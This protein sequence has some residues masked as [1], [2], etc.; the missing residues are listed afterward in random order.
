M[1]DKA[2]VKE[3]TQ[4]A[5]RMWAIGKMAK[6]TARVDSLTRLQTCIR[7][8]SET[9]KLMVKEYMSTQME[10]TMKASGASINNMDGAKRLGQTA[11]STSVH[12]TKVKDMEKVPSNGKTA[13]EPT[14]A[15]LNTTRFRDMVSEDNS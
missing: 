12:T 10:L 15:I 5:P 7:E 4:M 2:G 8:I 13:R 14:L 1:F 11:P 9:I 3:S 6:Q